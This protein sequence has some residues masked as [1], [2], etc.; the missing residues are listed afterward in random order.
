MKSAG[1]V[2][3]SGD[4]FADAGRFNKQFKPLSRKITAKS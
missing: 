2:A 4:R 1:R 3:L